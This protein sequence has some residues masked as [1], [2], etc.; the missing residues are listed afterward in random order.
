[1]EALGALKEPRDEARRRD[2][3]L[4]RVMPFWG[5]VNV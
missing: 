2:L 1:M 3:E 4:E 5:E